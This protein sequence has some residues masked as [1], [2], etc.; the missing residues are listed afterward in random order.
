MVDLLF[1]VLLS[2]IYLLFIFSQEMEPIL[3]LMNQI[4][5]ILLFFDFSTK[6][7]E[8]KL[9]KFN[10]LNI[11]LNVRSFEFFEPKKKLKLK[12]KLVQARNSIKIKKQ[13]KHFTKQCYK[14]F[15]ESEHK[16]T[17][18]WPLFLFKNKFFYCKVVCIILL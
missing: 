18:K 15:S 13:Q 4:L 10:H 6:N 2:T 17:I 12:L 5:N 14:V 3:I 8:L 11:S 1:I 16:K 9:K 7:I